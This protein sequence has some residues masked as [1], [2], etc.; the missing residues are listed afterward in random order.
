MKKTRQEREFSDKEV[1]AARGFCG[2]VG[3]IV[4][5]IGYAVFAHFGSGGGAIGGGVLVALG[6]ALA[7]FGLLAPRRACVNA[8]GWILMALT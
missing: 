2:V 4:A 3:A 7:A 1:L 8:A 6:L 5:G